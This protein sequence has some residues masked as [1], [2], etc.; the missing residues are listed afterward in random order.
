MLFN[1]MGGFTVQT[2][3]EKELAVNARNGA[4]ATIRAHKTLLRGDKGWRV[5]VKLI[6]KEGELLLITQR[7]SPK[8]WL[9]HDR[10]IAHL[11]KIGLCITKSE[12]TFFLK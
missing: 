11:Q 10:L 5:A 6:W 7:K 9:S 8:S 1:E 3:T 4:V 12:T 2:I